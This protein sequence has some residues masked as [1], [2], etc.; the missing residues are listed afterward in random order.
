[1]I[2]HTKIIA[3]VGPSSQDIDT[4]EK[5]II[6]GV[7]IFRL[8]FSH[9]SYEYHLK[10]LNN[11]REAE[12]RVGKLVAILQ[13]ISGPKIRIGELVHKVG[14]SEGDTIEFVK[15]KIIGNFVDANHLRVSLNYP[16]IIDKVKK[17]DLIYLYDGIIC[18]EIFEVDREFF[19]S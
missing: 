16:K 9:G 12:K 15:D 19:R 4:L 13:D 10:S 18:A 11:I 6:E 1:M 8:N 7:D 17:G 5:M 2:K 3:T 14:L